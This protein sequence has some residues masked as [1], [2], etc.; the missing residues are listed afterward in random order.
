[1]AL[2][3]MLAAN[4]DALVCDLAETYGI[5]DYRALPVPLLA[6]LA[7]GLREDSRIK[8]HLAGAFAGT[9]T[10]LLAAA[11]DRLSFLAWAKTKDGQ[12]GRK[13]PASILSAVMGQGRRDGPVRAFHSAI[14]FK[15]AWGVITEEAKHGN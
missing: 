13:R 14:D 3:G 9:D 11:V 7:V 8:L 5:F 15:T 10:L 1:M 12:V 4:E 6:T 2:A